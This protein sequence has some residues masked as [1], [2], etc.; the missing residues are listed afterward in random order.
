MPKSE[1][2]GI[3][4]CKWTILVTVMHMKIGL[5]KALLYYRYGTLWET[6]FR[7]LQFDVEISA[8]TNKGM[9][10]QGTKHALDENCLPLKIFM[11]HVQSLIGNCDRILVPRFAR[12]GKTEEYCGRFWGLPDLVRSTFPDA[13]ILSYNVDLGRYGNEAAAFIQMGKSLEKSKRASY[14][15]YCTGCLAQQMADRQKVYSQSERIRTS[16]RKVLIASQPYLIH[17]AYIGGQLQNLIIER[18]VTPLFSDQCCRSLCRAFSTEISN[19]LY[20]SINKE[21]IG[22]IELYKNQV[23][24]I[25]LLTAFP[26]GSDSLVNELV[27]RK[28]KSTP[29]IQILLDEHTAPAGLETR[30][31]SF[32]DIL[33]QRRPYA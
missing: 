31:E 23:D 29:M 2:K 9:L 1:R 21:I 6:F 3:K 32:I 19:S 13:P 14:Q 25:I 18:G 15:A 27:L 17:D 33:S 20:W 5:P 26:C 12:T 30:I 10:K 22:A 7:E 4:F 11:G 8:D 28:V 16:D 24:G